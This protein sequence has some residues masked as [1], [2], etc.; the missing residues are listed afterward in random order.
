[1]NKKKVSIHEMTCGLPKRS[2]PK[3]GA[4]GVT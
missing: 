4:S 1:M 3:H 2:G